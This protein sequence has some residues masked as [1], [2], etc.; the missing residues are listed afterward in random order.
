MNECTKMYITKGK[1]DKKSDNF[2]L[3]SDII[4]KI[5]DIFIGI[6]DIFV[7]FSDIYAMCIL[8]NP[9]CMFNS[10]P[11]KH[12]K[13]NIFFTF[14]TIF[15]HKTHKCNIFFTFSQKPISKDDPQT[16]PT[17]KKQYNVNV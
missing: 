7:G 12:T 2:T 15:Q 17:P 8:K 4:I 11:P 9:M 6:S 5:S 1:N 16:T 13:C 10:R 3:N 14:F